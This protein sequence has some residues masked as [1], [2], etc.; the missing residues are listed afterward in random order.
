MRVAEVADY[1]ERS[2]STIC[3]ILKQ[4]NAIKNTKPSKGVTILSKLRSDIH[5]KMEKLLLIWI[6]EKHLVGDSVTET[7][8][9]EKASR[10]YDDLKGKQAA[11]K[12]ETSTAAETFKA[13]RGWLDNFKKRSGIH[14][15]VRHGEAASSDAKSA[16]DFVTTFALVIAQHGFIP[17]QV[18]NCD[19]TGLF[20]KMLRTFIMAEKTLP[21]H[22]PMKNR[23][24][25]ALC[26]NA[27]GDF[28]GAGGRQ[29]RREQPCR[30]V[31]GRAHDT[32]I[33]R[34]PGDATF[35]GV[36]GAQ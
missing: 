32:G 30:G 12:V 17:Q 29:G 35:G 26:A 5:D 9:C 24:I 31:S 13:S 20:W 15:V 14:L 11:E 19:E 28:H 10:I 23:L 2:T 22:K 7:I 36:A 27:S 4:K 16:A 3:T 1:Y 33:D 25:L 18:F 34:A 6:K 8:I 21:G